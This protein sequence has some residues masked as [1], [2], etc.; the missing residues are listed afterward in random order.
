MSLVEVR[1]NALV[2]AN[3]SLGA[4]RDAVQ[5]T[6][7][8]ELLPKF[9]DSHPACGDYTSEVEIAG[10]I[11]RIQW[12]TAHLL[13]T[14]ESIAIELSED[15]VRE[16][17]VTRAEALQ[18]HIPVLALLGASEVSAQLVLASEPSQAILL[19]PANQRIMFLSLEACLD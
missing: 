6:L 1:A 4:S 17:L 3:I 5:R 11:A 8:R 16:S 10:H 18:R 14:V 7:R 19:K 9:D 12:S 2:W 15:E 13:G